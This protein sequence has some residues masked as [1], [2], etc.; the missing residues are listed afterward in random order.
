MLKS[1][2]FIQ[3]RN[4]MFMLIFDMAN[5]LFDNLFLIIDTTLHYSHEGKSHFIKLPESIYN[6]NN[7]RD[8]CKFDRYEKKQYS[9]IFIP[10]TFFS[11]EESITSLEIE[12]DSNFQI[13]NKQEAR[14]T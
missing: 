12:Y 1:V 9:C 14:F 4:G 11:E 2:T 7:T 6:G 8:F 10:D 3:Y 5:R 13:I